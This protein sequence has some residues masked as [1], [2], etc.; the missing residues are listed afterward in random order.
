VDALKERLADRFPMRRATPLP[1]AVG[2]GRYA[3]EEPV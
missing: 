3:T 1:V 2:V